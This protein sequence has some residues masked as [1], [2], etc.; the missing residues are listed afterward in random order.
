MVEKKRGFF[1]AALATGML[2]TIWGK[3]RSGKTSFVCFLMEQAVKAGYAV[4]TN[5]PFFRFDQKDE[6]IAK[7]YLLDGVQYRQLPKEI[8]TARTCSELLRGLFVTHRNLTVL[9]EAALFAASSM[10]TSTK[11]RWLKALIFTIGKLDSAIII[12][13]QD[14][15]SVVP[16]IRSSLV[17]YEIKIIKSS[18]TSR[19]A[20]ISVMP[21]ELTDEE[22]EPIHIDTWFNLKPTTLTFDSRAPTKFKFDIDPEVFFD[23][24]SDFNSLDAIVEAPRLLDELLSE[25]SG[26]FKKEKERSKR[27]AILDILVEDDSL[28][29]KQVQARTHVLGIDCSVSHIGQVRRER[30]LQAG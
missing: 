15:G 7:G 10:G 14:K 29:D 20:E 30:E 12:I 26:G 6:A 9:D 4:Y 13:A 3:M 25:R 23:R 28:T 16:A 5:I 18:D 27:E 22:Q 17:S 19:R 1:A 21:Q 24:I 11:V 8:K 2:L